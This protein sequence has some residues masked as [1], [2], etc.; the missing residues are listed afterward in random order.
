MKS[1]TGYASH[2]ASHA[3]EGARLE[4]EWDLRSVN[5]RGFDLRLRLPEGYVFLEKMIREALGA[6]IA[7]G[8]VSLGLRVRIVQDALA[9]PIDEGALQAL[10]AAVATVQRRAEAMGLL[11][12]APGALD[13]LGWRGI[14]SL[15]H[16]P[17]LF[18]PESLAAIFTADLEVLLAQF[19][20]MRATEGRALAGVLARQ[21]DEIAALTQ[22]AR[23][24]Q[25]TRTA[26]MQAHFQKAL[27]QVVDA[28]RADPARLEQEL[29]LLAVKA[30]IAEE[31]DR[32]AAHC[33]AARALVEAEGAVGRKLDFLTQE[34]N[35][36]AN[37]LCSKAQHLDMTRIGLDLKAVIDQMREQV[38][39]VE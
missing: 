1:M 20:Q 33:D 18:P 39:N 12:Q 29:A 17:A 21:I 30:D 10:L 35:R 24:L 34:F 9:L 6:R 4:V 26:A 7:R 28:S 16:D 37:T 19:E 31:L 13:L 14:Q 8:T 25:Q 32:L 22:A 27:A 36:E 11:L 23:G 15:G 3:L 5:A 38:Q 2:A